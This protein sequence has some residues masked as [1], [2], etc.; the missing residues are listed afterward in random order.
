MLLLLSA[1]SVPGAA[2]VF[3]WR[4]FKCPII[5]SST[6]LNLHVHTHSS[7]FPF[8]WNGY[9]WQAVC[10]YIFCSAHTLHS[11]HTCARTE[12]SLSSF[13]TQT[14]EMSNHPSPKHILYWFLWAL[15]DENRD[16]GALPWGQNPLLHLCSHAYAIQGRETPNAFIGASILSFRSTKSRTGT[17]CCSF[18]ESALY[19]FPFCLRPLHGCLMHTSLL[20]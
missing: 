8:Q 7:Y 1:I 20:L 15:F 4:C 12:C 17:W 18:P 9:F 11:V 16:S 6:A 10:L 14:P 3:L 2:P 19:Y 13:H 5:I